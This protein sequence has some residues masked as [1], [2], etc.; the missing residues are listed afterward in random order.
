[1]EPHTDY[2][3]HHKC[4][5]T[6][7][8]CYLLSHIHWWQSH[9][10]K[11]TRKSTKLKTHTHRHADWKTGTIHCKQLQQQHTNKKPR[12]KMIIHVVNALWNVNGTFFR[13]FIWNVWQT[14]THT[15]WI[16]I[17]LV[18][19]V[20]AGFVCMKFVFRFVHFIHVECNNTAHFTR[21]FPLSLSLTPV[22]TKF[23]SPKICW[24]GYYLT[25]HSLPLFSTVQH[26]Y[27]HTHTLFIFG[28]FLFLCSSSLSR[29]HFICIFFSLL[30]S[31]YLF[32]SFQLYFSV[33]IS[34]C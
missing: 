1:M 31:D 8:R 27:T 11:N 7:S 9:M 20:A 5:S 13:G 3:D 26:T 28:P 24:L 29:N 21:F 14:C 12:C 19:V 33:R 34:N 16:V 15:Q 18:V 6:I 2:T 23:A 32:A 22:A 10:H 4:N 17:S 25:F 30:F